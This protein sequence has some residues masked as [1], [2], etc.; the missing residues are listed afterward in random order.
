LSVLI[1]HRTPHPPSNLAGASVRAKF[2]TNTGVYV[3]STISN[4]P[5]ALHTPGMG[6]VPDADRL[7]SAML[8]VT[9]AV[10]VAIWLLVMIFI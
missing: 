3:V 8:T 1:A 5:S 6:D 2:P 7:A 4:K 10:V 9:T